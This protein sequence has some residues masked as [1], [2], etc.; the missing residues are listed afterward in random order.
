METGLGAGVGF[1]GSAP[2]TWDGAELASAIESY[3]VP[4]KGQRLR[5][6][7]PF[8]QE[9]HRIKQ[10]KCTSTERWI[11]KMWSILSAVKE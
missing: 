3:C 9:M 2:G 6:I 1:Q 5:D 11:N 4:A 7:I 8:P 10:S